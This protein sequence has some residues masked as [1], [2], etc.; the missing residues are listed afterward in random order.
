[1]PVSYEVL[2]GSK[3]LEIGCGSGYGSQ[4]VLQRFGAERIDAL[5]LDP[6]MIERARD[7]LASYGDRTNVVCG[8]AADLRSALDAE[9]RSYDAVFHFG[10]VHHIADWRGAVAEA[11]RVL[12]PSG[13][14]TSEKS[15]PTPSAGPPTG[16]CSTISPT[17]DSPP[18]SFLGSCAGTAC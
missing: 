2:P 11:A 14:S 12:T 1:M 16:D 9:D 5:D 3:A 10:I 15:P 18:N 4:L 6:V 17:T 8:S 13:D 7:R